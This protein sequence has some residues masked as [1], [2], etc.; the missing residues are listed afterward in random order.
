M[1]RF[2]FRL[3]KLLDLREA[4]EKEIKSELAKLMQDQNAERARQEELRGGIERQRRDFG[5]RFRRGAYTPHEAILFERYVDVSYRAIEAAE[6]RIRAM[7]PAIE[8]VRQR[9]VEASRQKKVVEKLKE[10]RRAEYEYETNRE[11]M[12]ENDDMNQKIFFNRLM[13][14]QREA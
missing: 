10:R 14:Q 3:Q 6:E 4:R 11:L 1:K 13:P 7:E 9:L 2:E 5:E 8:K 12:K